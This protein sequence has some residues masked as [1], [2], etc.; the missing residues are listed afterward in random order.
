MAPEIKYIDTHA[1]LFDVVFSEDLE[2]VLSRARDSGVEYIIV[3]ATNYATSLEA[4]KL[5]EK[6]GMIFACVGIHP[7]EASKCGEKDL[8]K[9]A[10]LSSHPKVVAI[11]EIGLDYHYDFSPRDVQKKIF[12]KQMEMAVEKKL[13]TVIHT[14]E[15]MEDSLQIAGAAV[16][17]GKETDDNSGMN[18]GVFHCFSGTYEEALRIKQM[19]FFISFTGVITFDRMKSAEVI[20]KIGIDD[21]LLETDSPYMS[22]VPLR[23]KRNEPSNIPLI[24]KKVSEI[25]A[26]EEER[27]SRATTKNAVNLFRLPVQ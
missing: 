1:H 7:H 22:P 10:D 23:G 12:M 25:V 3:P 4:V 21:L 9:I 11:G 5:A 13:P 18:K 8:D 15:S 24:G 16:R 27:V 26:L 19:G 17:S 2:D 14:R 20:G 6:Y